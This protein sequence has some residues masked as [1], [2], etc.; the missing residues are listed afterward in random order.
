MV[1]KYRPEID[2]LRTL[3]V[4]PVILFHMGFPWIK[5]GY[6][7][8]D[9]FFVISGFLI[10]SNILKNLNNQTFSFKDFWLRRIKRIL[11]ALYV[12]ILF[13]LLVAPYLVFRGDIKNMVS[14]AIPAML[15]YSNFH[16]LYEFGDY[17]GSSAEQSFFL[18]CWSLSVE[19]QFYL[20]YPGFLFLLF[21]YRQNLKIWVSFVLLLSFAWFAYGLKTDPKSTF[22]LLPSRAWELA[23]GSMIAFLPPL[24]SSKILKNL[25][26][27]VGLLLIL[28]SYTNQFGGGGLSLYAWMPVLGAALFIYASSTTEFVGKLMANPLFV[29]IGKISYSLY[30]WH[31]PIIV[32]AKYYETRF[33][34]WQIH[35]F[36]AVSTFIFALLSYELVEK[37]TRF[38]KATPKVVLSLGIVCVLVGV[39]YQSNWF[40]TKYN[41]PFEKVEFYGL[42]YDVTPTIEIPSNEV[43]AKREGIIIPLRPNRFNEA[44]KN[45]GI[46]F[47]RKNQKPK[48]L[49]IGD[50]HGAMWGKTIHE[51]SDS[52]QAG[53]R[54]FTTVGNPPFF[55][56]EQVND[57]KF[58]KGYTK[59]QRI[60]MVE[61]FI[62]TIKS[63]TPELV[64]LI[65]RWEN[66]KAEHWKDFEETLGYLE[67]RDIHCLVLNQPPR[68]ESLNDKNT[69][70]Y[71]TFLGLDPTEKDN[72][73]IMT[74]EDRVRKANQK[75]IDICQDYKNTDIF[76][77]YPFFTDDDEAIVTKDKE[78][79]YHD[80]DH[81]SNQGTEM[82]LPFLAKR[83]KKDL[84]L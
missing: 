42:M 59:A 1:I 71:F 79:L 84:N 17:W 5:G 9:V 6:Y 83:I 46:T 76:D 27:A 7:G 62:K 22:Y 41:S 63:E 75:L 57:Q 26:S 4:I 50:S 55:N 10:T 82:V 77:V 8:V 47:S 19:E 61:S 52:L 51:I 28:L 65:A 23:A 16:A 15:S 49:V 44:Y 34:A 13:F 81:L 39:F 35:L 25:A 40:N 33:E 68:L 56:L 70:Q 72:A 66:M 38:F 53:V 20:F 24:K 36:V 18:H 78:I 21:K 43:K 11:P 37:R 3:A 60:E 45:G 12:M 48:I 2:A 67:E 32:L 73:L 31:W 58:R 14:D 29:F 54:Y 74:D 69:G 30:L 80:D 64:I